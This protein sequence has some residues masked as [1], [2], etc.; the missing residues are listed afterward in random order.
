MGFL[1]FVEFQPLL[2]EEVRDGETF[3]ISVFGPRKI[4]GISISPP[5]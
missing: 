4:I 2:G 3:I 5:H 1:G